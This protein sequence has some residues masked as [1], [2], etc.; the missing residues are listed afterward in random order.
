MIAVKCA[1]LKD[2]PAIS[3]ERALAY[4]CRLCDPQALWDSDN[5]SGLERRLARL[6]GIRNHR[7]RNLG[8][9]AYQLY[10]EIDAT[11]RDEFRFR[12]FKGKSDKILLSS[13]TNFST[14]G[15]GPGRV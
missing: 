10:A 12:L 13:T 6:L 4:N 8:E 14:Q 15:A 9:I 2:Y 1:F 7:R 3:S 5:V 11:P